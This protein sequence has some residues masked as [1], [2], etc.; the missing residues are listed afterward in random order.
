MIPTTGARK[1]E[2]MRSWLV[3]VRETEYRVEARDSY[4]KG[5]EL[6]FDEEVHSREVRLAGAIT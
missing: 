1:K 4:P 3:T 2:V 6:G 5:M